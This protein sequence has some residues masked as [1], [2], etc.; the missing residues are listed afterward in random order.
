MFNLFVDSKSIW[1][2]EWIY[3][4][5]QNKISVTANWFQILLKFDNIA[6]GWQGNILKVA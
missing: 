4:T 5:K 1:M 6:V 3:L 2:D